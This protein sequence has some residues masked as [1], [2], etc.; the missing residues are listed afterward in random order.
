M[1]A[2]GLKGDLWEQV[3]LLGRSKEENS[4]NVDA[5]QNSA[6]GPSKNLISDCGPKENM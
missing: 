3:G 4:K 5:Y 2:R 1:G 6:S